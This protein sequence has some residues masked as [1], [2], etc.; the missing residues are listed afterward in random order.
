MTTIEAA[1]VEKVRVRFL[2]PYQGR[3]TEENYYTDGQ[4]GEFPLEDAAAIVD[5]GAAVLVGDDVPVDEPAERPMWPQP[6]RPVAVKADPVEVLLAQR[7][8]AQR[9]AERQAARTAQIEAFFELFTPA[10]MAALSAWLDSLPAQGKT[11][12]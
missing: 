12:R 5:E 11:K 6:R 8:A 2:H 7:E 1:P 10:R 4:V 3:A 9:E